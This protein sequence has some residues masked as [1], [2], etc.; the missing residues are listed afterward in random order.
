[1]S[2]L[3]RVLVVFV[4]IG[5]T[6]SPLLAFEPFTDGADALDPLGA[7][8]TDPAVVGAWEA[9]FDG[10]VP[11]VNMALLADGRVLYYSGVEADE[12][13]ERHEATFFNAEPLWGESRILK[14]TDD[15]PEVTT[16]TRPHG[17][18]GD[19]FCS[20]FVQL[21]D[22]R[23]LAAGGT[24]WDTLPETTTPVQGLTHAR[25]F[26]PVTDTWSVAADMAH[27][28]W[29]PS[30]IETPAGEPLVVSGIENLTDPSTM[31][32]PW[33][34]YDASADTWTGVEDADRLL[35]MYPR[36][37][38][39]PGGPLKGDV[40][41]NTVGTLWGPFGEHPAEA[42][43][44]LQQSFDPESGAWTMHGPSLFGARQHAATIMLPLS[45]DD[46]YAPE[47]VTFGGTL[48]RSLAAVP[49]TERI[50][51][52]GDSP[53]N[54]RAAD[55]HEGRWHLNGV[56]LPTGDVL[57][58]GGGAYDNVV[59]HGQEN[60][61]VMSAELYDPE[62]DT[63]TELA[64]MEVPRMY[65][66]TATLLPDGRVLVGGHVPL[67]NPF[68]DLRD[69]VNPQVKES[70]F[71]IFD[72]PYMFADSRPELLTVPGAVDYH[73]V[74]GVTVK[75]DGPIGSV[76]LVKP[77]ATTHAFDSAQRTVELEI[78][79]SVLGPGD[80]HT[81]TLRAPP[82][83]VVAQPGPWMLFANGLDADGNPVPSE[84]DFVTLTHASQ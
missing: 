54:T 27:A 43:W 8:S 71:E 83:S 40:F 74:F 65:H 67:P 33:E 58:V 17:A 79:D 13:D 35:P 50:D 36:V 7:K 21:P 55:M 29:Y 38:V 30:V 82:D 49:F 66:S 59:V 16:P 31:V 22:G 20:G 60:V 3:S 39:V 48:Q 57:A 11:A 70:R 76:V 6:T 12:S 81:L 69:T 77:G 45:A 68:K 32:L 14:L 75:H 47:Y 23:I 18:A 4:T 28:R 56:L 34:T 19:L 10:E 73:E 25:V 52:S 80:E 24:D 51:L 72:P 37:S 53:V 62:S 44:S 42:T 63:W 61:P 46:G 41:Y 1:M 26:D 84:A 9:P 64:E 15:G 78:I 5:L 2:S